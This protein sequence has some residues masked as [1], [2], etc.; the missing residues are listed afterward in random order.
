MRRQQLPR[1]AR[2]KH[3]S[4]KQ[5]RYTHFDGEQSFFLLLFQNE[6]QIH[7]RVCESVWL[8]AV[9]RLVVE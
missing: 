5:S 4:D 8:A 9:W 2:G 3:I 6:K 7:L 1:S